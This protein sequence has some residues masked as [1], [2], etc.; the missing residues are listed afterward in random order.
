MTQITGHTDRHASGT[1]GSHS[2]RRHFWWHYAEMVVV[3]LVGMGA[4]AP[5]WHVGADL[6]GRPNLLDDTVWMTVSMVV[7][8][9][10]AMAIWMWIRGHRALP[11]LEMSGAMAGPFL[12]LAAPVAWGWLSAGDLLLWGHV[13][14]LPAMLGVMLLRRDEYSHHHGWRWSRR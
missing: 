13:L 9:V 1:T 8:M 3:M 4:L 11:L 5:L 12:L 7:D 14:M 6:A 2:S 10:V